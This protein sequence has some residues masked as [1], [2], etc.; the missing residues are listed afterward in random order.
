MGVLQIK[1]SFSRSTSL[2][3]YISVL[4]RMRPELS[5]LAD[6]RGF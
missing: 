1:V 2:A 6:A 5:W 3:L 4:L